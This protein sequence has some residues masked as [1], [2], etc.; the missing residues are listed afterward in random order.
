[1]TRTVLI[2]GCS[3]GFGRLTALTFQRAGWNVVA[4]MRSPERE[5]E[6]GGLERVLLE[7]LDVTSQ[8]SVD[9]AVE[10]GLE[11]FGGLHALV[12]NAGVGG[13]AL[14]EQTN[15][16]SIRALYETNVF[17]LMRVTRAV[18]PVLRR[19]R[20]GCIVNVTSLNGW[21]GIPTW[22]IY[23]STKFAVEG[24][25]EALAFECAPV[26]VRVKTV[27]PGTYPTSFGAS[28]NDE[29]TRGGEELTALAQ[30][31]DTH[32]QAAAAAWLQER[33]VA[34]A[35]D[36]QDVADKIFECVTADT[37]LHNPVGGD[38]QLVIE[39]MS[40]MPRQ[41]FLDAVRPLLQPPGDL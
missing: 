5:S 15:D 2:T 14:F 31:I 28:V 12:N 41:A 29:M 9:R 3:S 1:M 30:H 11:R 13:H 4:T 39:M 37:P 26:G 6:L 22:S 8:D 20:D 23:S 21:A 24:F 27:A 34:L 33:G 36:P 10:H 17:G 18:L 35:A 40:T 16:E 38:A 32:V 7:P 19:Q 25:S